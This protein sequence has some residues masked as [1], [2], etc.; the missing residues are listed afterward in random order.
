MIEVDCGAID[1]DRLSVHKD[2]RDAF[3]RLTWILE[4][5]FI[6]DCLRIKDDEIGEVAFRDTAPLRKTESLCGIAR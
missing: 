3:C 1:D 6:V 2:M 4:R 5:R